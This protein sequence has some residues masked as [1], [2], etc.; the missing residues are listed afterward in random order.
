MVGAGED[1]LDS[2]GNIEVQYAWGLGVATNNEAKALAFLKG[3]LQ[4]KSQQARQVTV[5]GDSLI[6]LKAVQGRLK[7]G[8]S[9][10]ARLVRRINLE[11]QDFEA[12]AFFQVL[13][14]QDIS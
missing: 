14:H 5:V 4:L 1:I 10:L 3:N 13:W 9:S 8:H 12:I 2:R 7:T 6:I 11:I